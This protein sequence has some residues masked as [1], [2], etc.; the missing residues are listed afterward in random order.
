MYEKGSIIHIILNME[1][2]CLWTI[3][4][5]LGVSNLIIYLFLSTSITVC[6]QQNKKIRVTVINTATVREKSVLILSNILPDYKIE[7]IAT[8]AYY[9]I[10]RSSR[11]NVKRLC[12]IQWIC[13]TVLNIDIYN[14]VCR[15]R[16]SNAIFHCINK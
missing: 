11:C 13:Y 14:I 4:S 3:N 5:L 7:H 16:I 15:S 1:I 2:L 9:I 12:C 6:T 10:C 8:V